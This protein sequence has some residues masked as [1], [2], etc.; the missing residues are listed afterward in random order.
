MRIVYNCRE[1]TR[2][3][4]GTLIGAAPDAHTRK[5]G[6]LTLLVLAALVVTLSACGVGSGGSS[7]SSGKQQAP[8]TAGSSGQETE[9]A[10][11]PGQTS[12]RR[13]EHPA[14]GSAEAPVV[15]T[16]YSDYQ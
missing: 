14:L 5:L 12:E 2:L 10:E 13:L 4:G 11:S 16:E 8:E 3:G 7:Q 1:D 15:L 9:G 6:I